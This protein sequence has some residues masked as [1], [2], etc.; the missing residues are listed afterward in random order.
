MGAVGGMDVSGLHRSHWSFM[1]MC[2]LFLELTVSLM[3]KCGK[4]LPS[5]FQK[6][7]GEREK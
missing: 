1:N 4:M 7:E 2:Y 3:L 5:V 6:I